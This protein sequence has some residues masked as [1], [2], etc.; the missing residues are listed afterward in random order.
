MNICYSLW[1]RSLGIESEIISAEE[2]A[3]MCPF[4]MTD[5]VIG[6]LYKAS[7]VCAGDPS[8]IC[9][10]MAQG[11]QMQGDL[12]IILTFTVLHTHTFILQ[13]FL[14]SLSYSCLLS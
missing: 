13:R 11:A 7:D 10:A 9:R 3:A 2:C 8:D 5:D 12:N 4:L 6:A 1:S 14:N